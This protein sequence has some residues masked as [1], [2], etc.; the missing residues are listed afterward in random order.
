MYRVGHHDE[1]PENSVVTRSSSSESNE[2]YPLQGWH[3]L[4]DTVSGAAAALSYSATER[5]EEPRE[6]KPA[7]MVMKYE[8]VRL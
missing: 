7:L 4:T 8:E 3:G 1:F 2:K 6:V 5:E